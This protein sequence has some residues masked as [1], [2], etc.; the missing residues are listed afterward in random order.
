MGYPLLQGQT[1]VPIV[2]GP[3]V[4][5]A[6]HLTGATGLSPTVTIKKPGGSYASPSGAVTEWGN[7]FYQIAGNATDANTLGPLFVHA[8]GTG[9]DPF[10]EMFMVV[11]YDP[12]DAVHLGLSAIPNANAG[13]NGGLPLGDAS[14]RV[15]VGK[16]GG[17]SQTARDIGASVLL[18]PG[19]GTGQLDITSGV[20]KSNLVQIL[21]TALTETVGGY[22][23]AA[24]KKLF[25]VATPALTAA[26]VNQTGD[27]YTRI[28][29]NGAGLT[30]LGDTR[31]AHLDADVS[32]RSTFAGGAV[33]SVTGNV[34][35]NVTGSVGS[36]V[37]AVGSVTADVGITQAGADKVWG[38]ATRT[39]SAFG[40][41]VTVG[42]NNDK[43]DYTL[44]V[45]PPTAAAIRAEIDSNST[46][47]AAI[48][49]AVAGVPAAVW[50]VSVR[51]LS[52]FGTLVSDIWANASRTLSDKTGFSLTV[53]PPTAVQVRQ[54]MDSNSVGLAAIYAR[55]DVATSTR[56]AGSAY[57][58]PPSVGAID[59]QLSGTHGG[60]T[61]GSA[62]ASGAF[63]RTF[64]IR[65][66]DSLAPL[67]NALVTVKGS[68]DTT[69]ID[70]GRTDDTG[71][72]SFSLDAG[73]Y[74][75]HAA[76]V[77]GYASLA[78]Q[79]LTVA[80]SGSTTYGLTAI[81]ASAPAAPGLC[82]LQC[83]ALGASGQAL[84]GAVFTAR[85]KDTNQ[86]VGG[87]LLSQQI[88][89]GTTNGEGY[90]ELQLVQGG[91][92]VHGDGLYQITGK[93]AAGVTFLDIRAAMPDTESASLDALL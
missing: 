66:A 60:G 62:G 37:G 24:F 41:S 88:L 77:P 59:T 57:T 90:A 26:S 16:V 54:E 21:A 67:A 79:A 25:D 51:T 83:F 47:L 68:D 34:G 30:A 36:V 55:T 87:A 29:A 31:I 45:T 14:G 20:V 5:S 17:T 89:T 43:G 22:L 52:S 76:V 18:S 73:T 2:F 42:T 39:L 33:A 82:V 15:D 11:A 71:H 65:D 84:T 49:A 4:L 93:D 27:N 23:A 53:T 72:I 78:A 35:G 70:Q 56:L 58:A 48:V 61:W 92:F 12:R 38:T 69:L 28:G 50:A 80:G 7:G 74:S 10:D 75:I 13:A 19:T 64:L 85:L 9:C 6:D 1:A 81:T 8:V 91:Q 3:L 46:Q 63:T 44:T 86:A 32:S 40:F